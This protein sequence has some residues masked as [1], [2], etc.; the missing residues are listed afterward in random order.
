MVYSRY[1]FCCHENLSGYMC[2]HT[3]LCDCLC[4]PS[5]FTYVTQHMTVAH[6]CLCEVH[7]TP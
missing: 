4:E 1:I 5:M 7:I 6:Y 3:I 2:E